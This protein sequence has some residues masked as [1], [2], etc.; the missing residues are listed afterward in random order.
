MFGLS[1]ASFTLYLED[2][3]NDNIFLMLPGGSNSNALGCDV[4]STELFPLGNI[5]TEPWKCVPIGK[6]G[7]I[8][9]NLLAQTMAL[10][11]N[12]GW[13]DGLGNGGLTLGELLIEGS[14]I[15]TVS[16]PD[17][18][19]QFPDILD[20][21]TFTY[22]YIPEDIIL[23]LCSE[24]ADGPTINNLFDFANRLLGDEFDKKNLPDG[25]PY[26]I[27]ALFGNTNL[28]VTAINEA[29][30]GCKALVGFEGGDPCSKAPSSIVTSPVSGTNTPSVA[31]FNIDVNIVPNPFDIETEIRFELSHKSKV[32]IEIYD[33]QGNK[34]QTTYEGIVEAKE[35]NTVK[36]TILGVESARYLMCV[37]RTSHGTVTKPMLIKTTY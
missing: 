11:F 32:T 31:E 6:K 25:Y 10:Y 21:A 12:M 13:N 35:L 37:I 18:S 1:G 33:M 30:D 22:K 14:T 9:N 28:A 34:L 23:T 15:V 17:C 26:N 19:T 3:M 29:F 8:R 24:Y 5:K 20:P 36:C 4:N 27:N 16:G 2:I 7:D